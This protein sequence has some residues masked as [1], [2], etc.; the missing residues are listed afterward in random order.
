M[1]PTRGLIVLA[2]NERVFVKQPWQE[3]T[4]SPPPTAL[5][6]LRHFIK[7]RLEPRRLGVCALTPGSCSVF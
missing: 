7:I 5:L 3:H 2:A 4:A 6:L 1:K